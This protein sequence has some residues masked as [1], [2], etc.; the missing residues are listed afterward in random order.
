MRPDRI[1]TM[2]EVEMP[3][4]PPPTTTTKSTGREGKVLMF[5]LAVLFGVII[6]GVVRYGFFNNSPHRIPLELLENST[7][8]P[9][10]VVYDYPHNNTIYE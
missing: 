3:P 2:V 8:S 9:P 5:L 1:G 10:G 4:L 7:M 6:F